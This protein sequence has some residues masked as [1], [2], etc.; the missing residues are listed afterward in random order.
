MSIVK[1]PTG[2][3]K[4]P[5]DLIRISTHIPKDHYDL[6]IDISQDEDLSMAQ[7]IRRSIELYL[8]S[9]RDVLGIG[10]S[11]IAL[12]AHLS[13]TR[14]RKAIVL[15]H[16]DKLNIYNPNASQDVDSIFQELNP[17]AF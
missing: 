12:A 15:S 14:S 11:D 6:L 8:V 5:R 10:D 2:R 4:N 9:Q 3:P 1:R 17:D 13:E 7:V 16:A